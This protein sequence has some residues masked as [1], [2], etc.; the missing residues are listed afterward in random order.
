MPGFFLAAFSTIFI[1]AFLS[2]WLSLHTV[3][4]SLA[5]SHFTRKGRGRVRLSP[6]VATCPRRREGPPHMSF[7]VS[8]PETGPTLISREITGGGELN[9]FDWMKSIVIQLLGSERYLFSL[10]IEGS[11]SVIVSLLLAREKR[12]VISAMNSSRKNN[13]PWLSLMKRGAKIPYQ[14][15]VN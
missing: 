8:S 5:I 6:S 3:T 4:W 13:F 11:I 14:V 12:G 15:L 2:S 1:I 7:Y 10:D 9:S